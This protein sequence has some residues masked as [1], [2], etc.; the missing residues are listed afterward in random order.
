MIL[1]PA[2][3]FERVLEHARQ[4]APREACGWLAGV[5]Q[6]R[7]AQALPVPNVAEDPLT[8]FLMDP[9]YQLQAMRHIEDSGLEIVGTYHSHPRTQPCPSARDEELAAYPDLAHLI[10]SLAGGQPEARCF[11]IREDGVDE[12]ELRIEGRAPQEI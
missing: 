10:I 11:R 2:E 3:V 4:E 6:G 1:L 5:Q 12:V 9:E 8:C 7:V